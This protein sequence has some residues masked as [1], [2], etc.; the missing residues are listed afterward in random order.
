MTISQWPAD[1]RP[2]EKLIKYGAENLSDAELLAIFLRTGCNGFSAVDLARHLLN[3]FG[4][5]RAIFNSS[6]SDFCATKGLGLAKYCQ[7]QA[8]HAMATRC[9]D[10]NLRREQLFSS[11]EA[12]KSYLR[13]QLSRKTSEVFAALFL[14]TQHRLISYEELFFGT[15]DGASVYP[16]EVVK[17]ALKHNCAA[18]I[19]AHNHPSGVAEPSRADERI[20]KRLT[21]ALDL[22]DVRTLDHLIVGDNEV[23][24]FAE[25][26]LI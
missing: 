20:T 7:L 10:E 14:D 25:R 23:V 4:S 26:G 17:T 11:S 24:S 5:L 16:R 13:S 9:M 1:E 3:R 8:V 6:E 21:E 19:F 15:I 18:I 22:I 2:R 12:V